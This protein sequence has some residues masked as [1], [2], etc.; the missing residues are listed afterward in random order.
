MYVF[1]YYRMLFQ[2]KKVKPP[3]PL[4]QFLKENPNP[5]GMTKYLIQTI[6]GRM[7]LEPLPLCELTGEKMEHLLL[8]VI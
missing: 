5:S 4:F 1:I 8:Q 6:C 3:L 2:K 7:K